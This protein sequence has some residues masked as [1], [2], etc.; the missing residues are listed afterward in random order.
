MSR[1]HI[2]ERHPDD[3]LKERCHDRLL[4]KTVLKER[5]PDVPGPI[6]DDRRREPDLETVHV[7]TVHRELEAEQHIVDH[8]NGNGGSDTI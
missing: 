5:K 1:N 6:K 3:I 7:E 2:Q 4:S 8:T